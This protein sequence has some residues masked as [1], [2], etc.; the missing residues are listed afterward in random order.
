[1]Q[2]QGEDR[3]GRTLGR[4]Y[5]GDVDVNAA[6][7]RKGAAW[8]YEGYNKDPAFPSLQAQARRRRLGLWGLQADQVTPPWEWRRGGRGSASM[9]PTIRDRVAPSTAV[10]RGS[11]A[12][13]GK[14]RCGQ[15]ADCAEALFY[16]RRC[17][18]DRL[19]GDG[20]GVPCEAICR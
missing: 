15:M 3:Y 4:V 20:D 9:R 19:D 16:L 11:G 18:A 8:V 10:A 13:S 1:M 14:P 17:G 2:S 6:M 7:I 12:C 5:V